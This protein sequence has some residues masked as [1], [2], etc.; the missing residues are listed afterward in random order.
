MKEKLL[1]TIEELRENISEIEE[2]GWLTCK[3][4]EDY[5]RAD[6]VRMSAIMNLEILRKAIDKY[7][8]E[9]YIIITKRKGGKE[10]DRI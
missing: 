2:I 3:D 10:N 6:E 8:T 5:E 9:W 1:E 7:V 4:S